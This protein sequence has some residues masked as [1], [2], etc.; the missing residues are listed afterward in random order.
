VTGVFDG[1]LPMLFDAQ[2]GRIVGGR[3]VVRR[4]GGT[5]AYVGEVSNAEL[6]RMAKLAFDA[7]KSIRYN[8]LAIELDGALDGEIVSRVRFNGVNEAP[9]SGGGTMFLSQLTGFPFRFNIMI[10][11]PFRSLVNSA[12]S[13]NDPRGL[14]RQALP[15]R[16]PLPGSVPA[17]PTAQPPAQLP[18][19]PPVQAPASETLP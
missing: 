11:A 19:Q 16:T 15:G 10:A 9:L 17:Q 14:I 5:L 13:L 7:L 2:G 8:A 1:K 12:Q 6:G 18:V 3:L 4:G